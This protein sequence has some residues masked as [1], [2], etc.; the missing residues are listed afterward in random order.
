MTTKSPAVDAVVMHGMFVPQVAF[1]LSPQ[2]EGVF[3]SPLR[4]AVKVVALAS[5]ETIENKMISRYLI[6]IP[7][8]PNLRN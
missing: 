3:Q 7:G 1:P 2:V 5:H 8:L 4:V 6:T